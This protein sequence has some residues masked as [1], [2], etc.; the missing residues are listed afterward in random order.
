[1]DIEVEINDD[2]FLDVYSHLNGTEKDVD[3]DFLYGGR[4]SGKSRDVAQRL[5]KA[6]LEEDYFKC[7]LTRKVADTIKESQWDLI[8]SVVEEWSLSSLFKFNKS[9]L[10][11]ICVNGNRF[12]ARGLDDAS[13]L[14]SVNNPTHC[15]VEEGNQIDSDDF[16]IILTSLRFNEGN[17][18]TWFT[19]NPECDVN[20]TDFWLYQEWFEH[21]DA[22]NWTWNKE[23][24]VDDEIIFYTARATHSTYKNN[25]YCPPK[26]KALYESYKKGKNNSYWYQTYTLGLWGY[27]RT[28]GAFWK[29]FDEEKHVVELERLAS[30]FHIVVDN[31]VTPYVSVQIWQIDLEGKELLQIHE[32][33]CAHPNNTASKA[34][35]ELSK[36]LR[37][38]CYNDTVF[39]YGDPSANNKSTVDD[40]GKSFF[41]K[42]IGKLTEEGFRTSNRVLRSHP[43]VSIS[44]DFVN[45][46]YEAN[47]EGW[48]IYIDSECRKSI[49]DYSMVKEDAVGGM[50]KTRIK[51]K[52][53]GATYEKYGHMS[54]CKRYFVTTV[55]AKE[56]ELFRNRKTQ[57]V[58]IK[59]VN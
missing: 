38:Q 30:T 42:F 9:P 31:N 14:K 33:P 4:D 3:I 36:W 59:I 21:T 25:P 49:E 8:K 54:D 26:R 57:R 17:V 53:T 16:T 11:I 55:L 37:R 7:I 28:G 10:E 51:D 23:V 56:F 19:F 13:K 6:C 20:Y 43:G 12:I 47:F 1:M 52:E 32:L 22:L 15:W 5:V 40:D 58:G 29:C 50:L 27:R 46:I 48:G 39:I 18:K 34:A 35:V 2:V 45:E 44:G 41:E 24:K